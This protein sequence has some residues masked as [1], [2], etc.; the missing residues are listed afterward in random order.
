MSTRFEQLAVFLQL[1]NKM[2]GVK[3]LEIIKE[4]V[5]ELNLDPDKVLIYDPPDPP[6]VYDENEL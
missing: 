1:T 6:D 2:I 5:K 3:N 4:M